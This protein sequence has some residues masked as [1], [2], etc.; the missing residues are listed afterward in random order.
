MNVSEN[1]IGPIIDKLI[2]GLIMCKVFIF[3]FLGVAGY[4]NTLILVFIAIRLLFSN[5]LIPKKL[6]LLVGIFVM[7]LIISY[8][9]GCSVPGKAVYNLRALQTFIFYA[10][11]I[12]MLKANRSTLLDFKK[13]T[14][15]VF[16]N[17]VYVINCLIMLMQVLFPYSF[18]AAAPA[19]GQ[20]PFY[21][22]LVSGLFMY[23]STHAVALFSC[24]V[25]L[26][27]MNR[28]RNADGEL[29]IPI[30]C[31]AVFVFVSALGMAALNDNKALF[32][33]MPIVLLLFYTESLSSVIFE[34]VAKSLTFLVALLLFIISLCAINSSFALFINDNVLSLFD[35]VKSSSSLGTGAVG[36]GERIAII[37]YSFDMPSSWFFG[38]GLGAATFHEGYF[39]G[40]THFGQADFGSLT[41]LLGIWFLVVLISIYV[42]CVSCE[43]RGRRLYVLLL[44]LWALALIAAIYTQCFTRANN[45]VLILF[46]GLALADRWSIVAQK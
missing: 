20:I 39:C 22:D 41:I 16:F 45:S 27:D 38:I 4:I 11:Y 24:F 13:T 6:L 7:L 23:A 36:S 31:C 19:T 26:I 30:F 43:C 37:Q 5:W 9:A 46:I 35:L 21:D 14:W 33:L 29:Q 40:F 8:S 17:V 2:I 18:M 3:E 10:L 1:S 32:A 42:L 44:S 25:L 15:I 34:K 12:A 28:I